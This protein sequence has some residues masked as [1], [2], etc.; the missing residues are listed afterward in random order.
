M[1]SKEIIPAQ[2]QSQY[3]MA[4]TLFEEYAAQL[5][6]DLCFQNFADE[7]DHL[8]RIYGP[9]FG[10]LLLGLHEDAFVACVGVRL[11]SNDVCEL[12]RL[13]VRADVRQRGLGRR[14][15]MA[16][17]H[18]A[19]ELGY[20]RMVLD[21]LGNMNAARGLYTSLGFRHAEAYY[22][23]PNADVVYLELDLS[24]VAG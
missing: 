11:L 3:A 17:I 9:P 4:R 7:L 8:P 14:L 10:R 19:R 2:E 22:P 15:T 12:K 6:V 23:N 18:S 24:T 21:T 20:R 16:A 13:Y 5:G 1:P